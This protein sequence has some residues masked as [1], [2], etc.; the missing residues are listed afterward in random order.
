MQQ[1]KLEADTA[2][3]V[4]QTSNLV[5]EKLQIEQQ[6]TNLAVEH[7]TML[8]Q[9]TKLTADTAVVVQQKL[10]LVSEQAHT[11][12]QTALVNQQAANA[13]TEN[14]V[15]VAQECKLRAEYDLTLEQKLRTVEETGLLA[16]KKATE[17][18]QTV[19]LGVDDNS[20]IGR[21]KGL[22]QA[23][24]D[25]FTRDAEQKAAKLLVDSWN[26][27]RTTDEATVADTVNRLD[28]ATVGKAVGKM[29]SGVGL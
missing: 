24:I 11:D 25:G 16:Q 15:L 6:T 19:E 20:V 12:A 29:L 3:V 17:R 23:Q 7:D 22:Y 21:Q 14:T 4:Q 8:L 13:V 26:V 1:P 2:L 9:Q 28:D 10:N 5:S 27:R 18:A